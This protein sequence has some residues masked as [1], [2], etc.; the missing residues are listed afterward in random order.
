M[1]LSWIDWTIMAV[2]VVL[3]R[4]VSLSTRRH[5]KGVADF[6]SA[7]RSAGR[8]LLTIAQQ[9]GAT[10]AISL[11]ALF[12]MYYQVGFTAIW[13]GFMSIPVGIII[14]LTGWV[15]YR[16]R[17]TRAL[18]LA[19]FLEMRYNRRFRVFAGLIC[20]SC[21]ILNFGIFPAVAARFFMYF[22]GL[23]E[24]FHI[25]W[26]PFDFPT[27]AVIMAIDLALALTFVNMGGQIS[28]M[29]TECAQGIIS[30]FIFI[31]VAATVMVK[32]SWPQIVHALSM[33]PAN[34]SMVHPIRTGQAGDFN[35]WY[36]IIGTIG[37]IYAVNSWQGT[38]G[39]QSSGRSAHEMKMGGIISMWRGTP[40]FLMS[41]LLPIAAYAVMHLPEFSAM[42]AKVN[43]TLHTIDNPAIRNQMRVPIALAHFLP[44]GI[45]G[46]LATVMLFFSFTCHDTY[47]HSWGSI[48]VQDV[49]MPIR[50]KPLTPEQHVRLLR[51]SI[52]GVA[53][54]AFF[55]S[56]FYP[57]S[58]KILMFFAITGTIWTGG[59]GAVI[60]G[61]L[62]T[63]RGTTAAAYGAMIVG[64]LVGVSGLIIPQIYQGRYHKEFPINGMW[65][66]MIAIVCALA[67]YTIISLLTYR[68]QPDFD[69]DKMLHRGKYRVSSEHNSETRV[70]S[71]WLQVVGITPEFTVYDRILAVAL[72]VWNFGLFSFFAV[73]T[74]VNLI[75]HVGNQWWFKFWHIYIWIHFVIAVPATIW[76]TVG[77]ILD[78]KALFRRLSTAVRD[79][80]DD[81]RVC[82]ESE[83]TQ[84]EP[85]PTI[86]A[87]RRN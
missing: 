77:G 54:F 30:A 83:E 25:A 32:L 11:V 73:A 29:I 37:A 47:M 46:L 28:V 1:N 64:A 79:N 68:R 44:I 45:K 49:Y 62:Y 56:L 38:S 14:L 70:S 74:A 27:F 81:G 8:Y 75:F 57:Q 60:I 22:C 61:G 5:M 26:I 23:P 78:M 17:E 80:S 58:Q 19:Q 24:H 18:T 50:N 87:V 86:D 15:Y 71:R 48:F 65:L 85:A 43:A 82:R 42:A 3:L 55:F 40:L 51:W 41:L 76:F 69:L 6:L 9:M 16:F 7:N 34:A 13:W 12:E 52:A 66:W 67:V 21:G 35:V 20:W 72:V 84:L 33:A 36:F 59:S 53:I 4:L 63:K 10:G 2:A 31:V 39:F